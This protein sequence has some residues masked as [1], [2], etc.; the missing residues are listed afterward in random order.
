MEFE[1]DT[2]KPLLAFQEETI[3]RIKPGKFERL[4][5][6]DS[7]DELE[8]LSELLS[9]QRNIGVD[10]K[11]ISKKIYDGIAS[12]QGWFQRIGS[13]DFSI[14]D[15]EYLYVSYLDNGNVSHIEMVRDGVRL[16]DAL[17]FTGI[18]KDYTRKI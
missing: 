16:K 3:N 4:F 10:V 17:T 13:A 5:I 1:Q 7:E 12:K 2:S 14:I 6:Y 9:E 15:N 11:I 8:E 18:I